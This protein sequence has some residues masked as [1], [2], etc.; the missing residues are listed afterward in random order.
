[1]SVT[2]EEDI[3]LWLARSQEEIDALPLTAEGPDGIVASKEMAVRDLVED[4]L[5]LA[6]PYAPRHED[7]P[8]DG[9]RPPG[10]R[11]SP[12]SGLRGMLRGRHRH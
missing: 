2:V 12:F 3:R 8:A 5:L 1:V 9:A 7:C 6:L 11:Q 4:E 10:A